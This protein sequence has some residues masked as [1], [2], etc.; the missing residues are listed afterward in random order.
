MQ[1]P[2]DKDPSAFRELIADISKQ[3]RKDLTAFVYAE[4]AF[5]QMW[6][7]NLRGG[8]DALDKETQYESLSDS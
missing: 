4:P 1:M 6:L 2:Y 3:L 5:K 7:D 8:L